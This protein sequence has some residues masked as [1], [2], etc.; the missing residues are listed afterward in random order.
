MALCAAQNDWVGDMVR[1]HII[2]YEN[3]IIVQMRQQISF[4]IPLKPLHSRFA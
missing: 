1:F 4:Q 2:H 3:R